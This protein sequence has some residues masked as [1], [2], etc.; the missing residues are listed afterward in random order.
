[1]NMPRLKILKKQRARESLG[2]EKKII[3]KVFN[4]QW[5]IK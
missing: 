4:W 3:P 1:M 2:R 5:P